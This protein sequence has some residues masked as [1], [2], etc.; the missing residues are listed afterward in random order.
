MMTAFL[1]TLL[2]WSMLLQL[3]PALCAAQAAN[4]LVRHVPAVSGGGTI[5]G[6]IQQTLGESLNMNG[7]AMITGDLLAPGSPTV[8]LN[9]QPNFGG[10]VAGSGSA[11]PS[12]YQITIN[13]NARLGRLLTRTDPV[14]LPS[15]SAPP[16]P[17]G[18]RSVT[19][20]NFG[21]RAHRPGLATKQAPSPISGCSTKCKLHGEGK[22]YL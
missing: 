11:S 13:G 14:A 7:G 18:T 16:V 12:N 19:S 5:E 22:F 17:T 21:R 8:R 15:V 1:R 20:P 9:G 2:V 3:V 10:T 4:A 6:S